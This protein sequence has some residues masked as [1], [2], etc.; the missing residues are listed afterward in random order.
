MQCG[1]ARLA[2]QIKSEID[3]WRLYNGFRIAAP[4][5][6]SRCYHPL[7]AAAYSRPAL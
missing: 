3:H 7:E 6:A 5:A 2:R 4:D 1:R